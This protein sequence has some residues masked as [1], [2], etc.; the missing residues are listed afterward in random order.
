MLIF[1][2]HAYYVLLCSLLIVYSFSMQVIAQT[3]GRSTKGLISQVYGQEKPGTSHSRNRRLPTRFLTEEA[4]ERE[5]EVPRG[6]GGRATGPAR[7]R[8]RG[9]G[10]SRTR[11]VQELVVAPED[12]T[13]RRRR[14]SL[15]RST[16]EVIIA[17]MLTNCYYS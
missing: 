11:P 14:V 10:R 13:R 8:G 1:S 12:T 9:R 15:T 4:G 7:G 17:I 16:S 2:Y 6:R 3:G 5:V